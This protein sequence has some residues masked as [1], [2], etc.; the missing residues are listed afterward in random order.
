MKETNLKCYIKNVAF[1]INNVYNLIGNLDEENKH[2]YYQE[3]N[4]SVTLSYKDEVNINRENA[5]YNI[6]MT[7]K[8]SKE[9]EGKYLLKGSNTY[10]YLKVLTTKLEI[11]N[12]SILINYNL[13]MANETFEGFEYYVEWS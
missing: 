9:V 2:L 11:K 12:N 1:S 5:E 3:D 8:L 7:F 6:N 13:T 10:I 4:I